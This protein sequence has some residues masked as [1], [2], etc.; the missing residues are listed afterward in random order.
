MY[1]HMQMY[2][3]YVTS[4]YQY[5]LTCKC[6]K[7]MLICIPLNKCPAGVDKIKTKIGSV[8]KI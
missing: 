7:F 8:F 5:T 6:M 1:P 4:I 3:I 2:E